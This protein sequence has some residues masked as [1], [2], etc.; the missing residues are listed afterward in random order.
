MISAVK[1][2]ENDQVV[3]N[4]P[5][6]N[7]QKQPSIPKTNQE[8]AFE[9]MDVDSIRSLFTEQQKLLNHFFNNLQYEPIHQFCKVRR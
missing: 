8:R 5:S 3:A 6:H 1:D 7:F 2:P 4:S 9:T